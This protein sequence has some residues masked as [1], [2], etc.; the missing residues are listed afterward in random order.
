MS[1]DQET[2]QKNPK[3]NAALQMLETLR[4]PKLG[5]P[6]LSSRTFEDLFPYFLEELYEY[7]EAYQIQ[8]S[9]SSEAKQELADLLF[10][11]LLHTCL[12]KET[13]PEVTLETIAGDVVNKLSRRHPHVFDPSHAR[14]ESAEAAAKAWEELKAKEAKQANRH[15]ELKESMADK[16]NRIPKALPSLQRAARIGEKTN[17]FEFDWEN[18][19]Q[20][21]EKVEEEIA[22]LKVELLSKPHKRASVAEELGDVLFSLAQLAR[23]IGYCPEELGSQANEKFIKRFRATEDLARRRQLDWMSLNQREREMLWEDAKAE[24]KKT[25]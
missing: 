13:N 23:H 19:S 4:D 24:L 17:S 5:C 11:V 21:F 9:N 7:K 8:G 2:L 10:Q 18:A 6:W 16:I 20:V 22:E 12:M 15:E 14:F 25:L 3:V 1:M